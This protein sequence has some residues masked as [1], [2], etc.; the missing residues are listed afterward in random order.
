M[1]TSEEIKKRIAALYEDPIYMELDAYFNTTNIFN[2]LQIERNETKHSAFIAWLL[3]PK[4]SHG[5]G[6]KPLRKFL[7]MLAFHGDNS[8][9]ENDM[10]C[11]L[12]N[13]SY[14]C[15][16]NVNVATEYAIDM[17]EK[18]DNEIRGLNHDKKFD[19]KIDILVSLD[20][21]YEERELKEDAKPSNGGYKKEDYVSTIKTRPLVVVVE[22]KIY[23]KESEN[24][25]LI[26]YKWVDK[27]KKDITGNVGNE[28]CII[29]VF[30]TPEGGRKC[31]ADNLHP[32]VKL[33]Y[34]DILVDFVEPLVK[35][36]I[37]ERNRNIL[38]DYMMNLCQPWKADGKEEY[39]LATSAYIKSKYNAFFKEER[40]KE[41]ELLLASVYY[42][43]IDSSRK[44]YL[45][46]R[47]DK[48]KES[49]SLFIGEQISNG[50]FMNINDAYCKKLLVDLWSRNHS[51]FTSILNSREDELYSEALNVHKDAYYVEFIDNNSNKKDLNTKPVSKSDAVYLVFREWLDNNTQATL[52]DLRK[53][54]P[55]VE[56]RGDIKDQRYMY[57]FYR[58]DTKNNAI[59]FDDNET[60]R[61]DCDMRK[62]DWVEWYFSRPNTSKCLK[63][64]DCD[65]VLCM[66]YWESKSFNE[67]IKFVGFIGFVIK[68][69]KEY[70]KK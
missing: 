28:Q 46:Q 20:I 12:C 17:N 39:I 15:L 33:S 30:L 4:G 49:E 35:C 38:S 51:L 42:A 3:D 27:N 21:K 58:V 69:E 19:K 54:F 24:Q 36:N 6:E 10:S 26:Y 31:S 23:T 22:N 2:I 65:K 32:F 25:T 44:D 53:A 62:Q 5:L 45:G 48:I 68:S 9:V 50:E 37:S 55:I 7:Q 64:V 70:R 43:N 13:D 29:G 1:I 57:M 60:E 34:S 8:S 41:L 56:C 66:K 67:F 40:K 59:V 14:I 18:A 52:D 16:N 61:R 63:T 11:L 47:S